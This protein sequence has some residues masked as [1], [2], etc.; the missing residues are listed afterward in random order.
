MNMQKLIL[1]SLF[2]IL[3]LQNFS[4]AQIKKNINVGLYVE[5]VHGID[6]QSS[7]FDVVFWVWINSKE[8]IY[9][10]EKELDIPNSTSIDISSISYDSISDNQFHSECK[11]RATIL[12]KFDVKNYP[13]DKQHLNFSI[14]FSRYSSDEI[15]IEI[16]KK[17]S[18]LIPEY[19]QDWITKSYESY[20]FSRDYG[21]NFGDLHTNESI[22]YPGISVKINLV[23]NSWNLYYKSFITLFLSFC[24]ASISLFYPNENSEEKI[25]LIVGSLFTTVGNKYVTDDILPIQNSLNLS[26]KLHLVTI[27]V[28]ALIAAYA[29]FEQRLKLKDSLKI[30][31]IVFFV[32]LSIFLSSVFYFTLNSMG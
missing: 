3:S 17:Q 13:F 6:Y 5:D 20:V 25:G 27:L 23:R 4:F 8:S 30:D 18:K 15:N 10:F 29:I 31:L 12:N 22:S 26:D 1:I 19:I 14:E 32:F 2:L 21:S 28:I 11:I 24:I 16:D 7:K 9:D